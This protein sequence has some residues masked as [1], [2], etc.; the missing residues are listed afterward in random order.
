[1]IKSVFSPGICNGRY[2]EHV[3]FNT[4]LL[5]ARFLPQ[6]HKG[7]TYCLMVVCMTSNLKLSEKD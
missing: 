6:W 3:G 7:A 5:V 4:Y 1:M 2:R